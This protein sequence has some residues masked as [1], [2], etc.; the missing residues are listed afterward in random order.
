[1][2][3]P[4]LPLLVEPAALEAA[5]GA[6]GL[7]IVWGNMKVSFVPDEQARPETSRDPDDR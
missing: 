2:S 6:P 4:L 1:M 5:L 7:L 3:E